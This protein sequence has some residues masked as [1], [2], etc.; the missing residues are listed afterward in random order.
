LAGP[1]AVFGAGGSAGAT[2]STL[3]V[4]NTGTDSGTCTSSTAPCA[5]VTYALT[6]AGSPTILV[7]GTIDDNVVVNN[8]DVT[9]AQDPGG[10]PAELNGTGKGPVITVEGF[11]I[12]TLNQLTITG[13]SAPIGGGVYLEGGDAQFTDSTI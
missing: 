9:I 2:T 7:S 11:T 1:L 3:Y 5:T 10:G 8:Q 6:Q 13:G 4:S 12:L